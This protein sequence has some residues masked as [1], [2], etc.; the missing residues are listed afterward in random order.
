MLMIRRG[1]D[2]RI[3]A[4]LRKKFVIVDVALC[5]GSVFQPSFEIRLVHFGDGYALSAE[6]LEI[7]AE[8]APASSRADQSICESVIRAPSPAWHKHGRRCQR[9]GEKPSTILFHQVSLLIRSTVYLGQPASQ[10][11]SGLEGVTGPRGN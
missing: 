9:R 6:L 1:D 4:R 7:A 10:A 3:H 5:S 11:R 2:H 8:V